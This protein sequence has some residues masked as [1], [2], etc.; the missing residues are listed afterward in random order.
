MQRQQQK[1]VRQNEAKE[2]P[3][4][5]GRTEESPG[6]TGEHCVEKQNENLGRVT[7]EGVVSFRGAHV[8]VSP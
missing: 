3:V 6:E 2:P 7:R 4:R 1:H 8:W 5:S